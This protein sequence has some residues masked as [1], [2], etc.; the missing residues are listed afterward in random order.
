LPVGI[1]RDGAGDGRAPLTRPAIR[2]IE[3]MSLN[4]AI[5][6]RIADLP[7]TM[8]PFHLLVNLLRRPLM[9][10]K[11]TA[12]PGH[13]APDWQQGLEMAVFPSGM[14]SGFGMNRRV[15]APPLPITFQLTA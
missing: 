1:Y 11:S 14:I 15:R 7:K 13:E 2:H 10:D 3:K 9:I 6:G 4:I 5:N 12:A 8:I